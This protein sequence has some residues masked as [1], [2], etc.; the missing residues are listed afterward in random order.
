MFK[1]IEVMRLSVGTVYKLFAIGTF[2]FVIPLCTLLGFFAMF[3][4]H[5][6]AWN[7]QPVTGPSG[8]V[9][10]PFIGAFIGAMFV[11]LWGTGCVVGLWIYSCFFSFTITVQETEAAAPGTSTIF[12][13]ASSR[14]RR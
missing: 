6:L 13:E 2:C 3:G 11:A 12:D 14:L 10:G 8:I 1:K 9:A 5:T 4:A 7:G